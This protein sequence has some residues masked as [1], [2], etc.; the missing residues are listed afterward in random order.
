MIFLK[1]IQIKKL[2]RNRIVSVRDYLVGAA[3]A[4]G[5]TLR[6]IYRGQYMDL[7]PSQLKEKQFRLTAV[8]FRSK[9]NSSPYAL[10]D[11]EWLPSRTI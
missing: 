10:I 6:L 5:E 4:R 1:T 3:I 7:S 2:F 9:Y 8:S 11:Y